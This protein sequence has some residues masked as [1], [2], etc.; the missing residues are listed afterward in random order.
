MSNLFAGLERRVKLEIEMYDQL[1]SPPLAL[2]A[3]SLPQPGAYEKM[4]R[5]EQRN[6]SAFQNVAN[7][8]SPSRPDE[9]AYPIAKRR[10][11]KEIVSERQLK[12]K[13]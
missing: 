9:R 2:L 8:S 13:Q 12:L 6:E 1:N 11:K 4:R 10:E 7:A 3:A 5:R